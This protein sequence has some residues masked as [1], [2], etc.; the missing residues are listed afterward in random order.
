MITTEQQRY[1]QWV[2]DQVASVNPYNRQ[3][4]N[5]REQ[6]EIYQSGYLAAYLSSLMR[7]DPFIQRRFS[8]HIHKNKQPK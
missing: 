4:A 1:A 8:N 7:E 5:S 2:L 6:F 3:Q